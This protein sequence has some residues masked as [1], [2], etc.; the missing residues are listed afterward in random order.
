MK[1][2]SSIKFN[3]TA[4]SKSIAIFILYFFSSILLGLIFNPLLDNQ[5][6]WVKTITQLLLTLLVCILIASFF[7]P[8]LIKDWHR[9]KSQNIGIAFRYWALGFTLMVITNMYIV[10]FKK[11]IGGNE[12]LTR[13]LLLGNLGLASLLIIIIS[14]LLEEIV[15]RLNFR[16]GFQN[17]WPFLV[18]SSLLFGWMHLT[19][20]S[21]ILLIIPYSILGFCLAKA[22]YETDN[23]W[24]SILAHMFHNALA[25]II[26]WLG[27]GLLP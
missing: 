10:Y 2:K 14:P 6:V 1:A 21:E 26:I 15:F 5:I 12:T 27:S 9:F 20:W 24:T 17:K 11:G 16:L 25:V 13:E 23:I 18:F 4:L 7:L 8:R 3:P 19:S 22:F